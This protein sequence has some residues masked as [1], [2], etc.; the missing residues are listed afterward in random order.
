MDIH[1]SI[2][3]TFCARPV[4]IVAT[5]V[6]SLGMCTSILIAQEKK[7]SR[8]KQGTSSQIPFAREVAEE[9]TENDR[10]LSRDDIE[11]L[12][13]PKRGVATERSVSFSSVERNKLTEVIS[14]FIG[15]PYKVGGN[16]MEG[17]DCGGFVAAV[18]KEALGFEMP[19]TSAEQFKRGLP[20][21]AKDLRFG[22]LVFFN[23]N[24]AS[25]SHVGIYLDDTLFAH[26]SVSLGVTISSLES[27]YYEKRLQ[28]GRRPKR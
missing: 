1:P 27:A 9:K 13:A 7:Q 6:L 8:L 12:L 14:K 19:Q 2:R 21:R 10:I 15:V 20:V 25:A 4:G 11:I 18:F 23:T 22:D 24:G 28:E 3:S 26:A 5:L 16:S 17:I